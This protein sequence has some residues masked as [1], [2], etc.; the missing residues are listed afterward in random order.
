MNIQTLPDLPARPVAVTIIGWLAVAFGLLTVVSGVMGLLAAGDM[1]PMAEMA[2][3]PNVAFPSWLFKHFWA[4]S[5]VQIVIAAIGVIAGA[6]FLK[7][8][9]WGRTTLEGLTWFCVVSALGFGGLWV[10]NAIFMTAKLPADP[11]LPVP[12]GLFVMVGLVTTLV[13]AAP[14]LVALYFLRSKPVR[15]AME[16][17][18]DGAAL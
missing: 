6:A 2:L 12:P 9:P 1:P 14:M 15:A 4:L 13:M 10:V 18:P 7:L 5:A 16:P 8:R 17:A 11:S 3:D